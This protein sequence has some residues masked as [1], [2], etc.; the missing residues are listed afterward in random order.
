M[1]HDSLSKHAQHVAKEVRQLLEELQRQGQSDDSVTAPPSAIAAPLQQAFVDLAAICEQL[2]KAEPHSI[3]HDPLEKSVSA[4]RTLARQ[5]Y[6]IKID[7]Q[8][9]G[10]V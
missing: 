3:H 5:W 10:V 2:A 7:G 6:A 9:F 4:L 1:T 8:C